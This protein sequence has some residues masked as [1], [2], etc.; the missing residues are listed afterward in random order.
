MHVILR[1]RLAYCHTL[2]QGERVGCDG[3]GDSNGE[4]F[5]Y[6]YSVKFGFF[7]TFII[8]SAEFIQVVIYY[9]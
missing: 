9:L 7:I 3:I 8:F 2:C 4:I 6:I 5:Y 1:A